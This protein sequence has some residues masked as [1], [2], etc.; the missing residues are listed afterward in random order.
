MSVPLRAVADDGYLL[1]LDERE[2]RIVIV[3]SL[4]HVF[5]G[6]SFAFAVG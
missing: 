2:V 3:K 6:S 5:L 1:G 4:C